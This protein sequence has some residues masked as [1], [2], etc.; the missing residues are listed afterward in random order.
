MLNGTATVATSIP[1]VVGEPQPKFKVRERTDI[2]HILVPL[3][4]NEN[5]RP[6]LTL[7]LQLAA[8]HRADITLL[9]V[10]PPEETPGSVHWLSA[11][12]NLHQSLSN[13]TRPKAPTV[14]EARAAIQAFF[15]REA[16]D[17]L[18]DS[19]QVRT[20]CRVGDPAS[21]IVRF[22]EHESVDMVILA[23][24]LT[25]WGLPIWPGLV[26]SV[27]GNTRKQ[28]VLVRPGARRG[29]RHASD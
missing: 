29:A 3:S 23:T 12:D 10:L 15:V 16:A 19:V 5:D 6:A 11:I 2:A 14:D 25:T 8:A 9:H 20:E 17:H 27:L 21:E 24:E 4:L 28:V 1:N 26:R 22:A 18:R 13:P 7:G